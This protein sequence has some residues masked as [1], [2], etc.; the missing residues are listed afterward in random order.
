M[1]G[2]ILGTGGNGADLSAVTAVASDV[3]K[4][5]V[6]VGPDG[7]PITGTLDT[8]GVNEITPK[9]TA[10]TINGPIIIPDSLTIKAVSTTTTTVYPKNVTQNIYPPSGYAGFSAVS[11]AGVKKAT[12]RHTFSTSKII[13][14]EAIFTD[15]TAT[16]I[17][18]LFIFQ[19]AVSLSSTVYRLEVAENFDFSGIS[20]GSVSDPHYFIGWKAKSSTSGNGVLSVITPAYYISSQSPV[21]VRVNLNDFTAYDDGTPESA[22]TAV[23]RG[24]YVFDLYYV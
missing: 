3:A 14:W 15:I 17:V 24:N 13:D 5:K 21:T 20:G 2:L 10:Q 11:V 9:S 23:F 16:R 22:Y 18:G 7:Q 12:L 8:Y 19:G 4:D 1:V 6:I